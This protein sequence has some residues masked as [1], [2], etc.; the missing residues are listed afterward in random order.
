MDLAL[1]FSAAIP[2]HRHHHIKTLARLTQPAKVGRVQEAHIQPRLINKRVKLD[3]LQHA[4]VVDPGESLSFGV[5]IF[6]KLDGPVV[7][8][9]VDEARVGIVVAGGGVL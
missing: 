5:P 8:L 6:V 9:G 1:Q 3:L 4:L 2:M 7:G